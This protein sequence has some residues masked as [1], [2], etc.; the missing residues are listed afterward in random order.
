MSNG[1]GIH[2]IQF[3]EHTLICLHKHI[4]SLELFARLFGKRKH[5]NVTQ[6]NK[7]TVVI[8]ITKADHLG[9]FQQMCLPIQKKTF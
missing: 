6:L 2:F 1:L 3:I 7:F 9:I 4:I 5:K 8:L